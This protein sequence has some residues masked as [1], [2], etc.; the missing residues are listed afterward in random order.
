MK[1]SIEYVFGRRGMA[2]MEYLINEV[3]DSEFNQLDL[4]N[5][6]R[7]GHHTVQNTLNIF[8]KRGYIK[9]SR[10]IA[11][12]FFYK[13]ECGHPVVMAI[14]DLIDALTKSIKN[15]GRTTELLRKFG[16]F[17]TYTHKENDDFI[18]LIKEKNIKK[19]IK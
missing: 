2:I 10:K 9:I 4:M 5:T 3:P 6:L 19:E 15:K 8:L 11:K 14:A 18:K 12:S 1:S 17:K 13:L 16:H 7:M